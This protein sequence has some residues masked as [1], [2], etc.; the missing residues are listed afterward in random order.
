MCEIILF[1]HETQSTILTNQISEHTAMVFFLLYEEILSRLLKT[2]NSF[3]FGIYL[4]FW[5]SF[6]LRV[7]SFTCK[8]IW[9]CHWPFFKLWSVFRNFD[10]QGKF[11]SSFFFKLFFFYALLLLESVSTVNN[12]VYSLHFMLYIGLFRMD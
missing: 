2:G 7:T 4:H 1:I 10:K 5:I 12:F 6:S 8:S 3:F 11:I 9:I